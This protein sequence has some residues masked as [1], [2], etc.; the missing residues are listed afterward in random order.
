MGLF[1]DWFTA[2]NSIGGP[3]T[4]D[5]INWDQTPEE[6]S[7]QEMLGRS[8]LQESIQ[9]QQQESLGRGI[10]QESL[11][12]NLVDGFLNGSTQVEPWLR[13]ID[14]TL[15]TAGRTVN[16]VE[17]LLGPTN[18][19]TTPGG[20]PREMSQS[21]RINPILSSVRRYLTV[22]PPS[23]NVTL[24]NPRQVSTFSASF[25]GW[26]YATLGMVAVGGFL[27]YRALK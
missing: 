18:R 26:D 22:S 24:G 16:Q 11:G 20:V 19:N 12:R 21:D 10:V 27:L 23:G 25:D 8:I 15:G 2:D 4:E 13:S 14:A 1:D 17:R 9:G 3:V 6:A 7:E 5:Y